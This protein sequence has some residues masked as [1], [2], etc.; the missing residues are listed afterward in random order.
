MIMAILILGV[1]GYM[2]GKFLD[3]YFDSE[4]VNNEFNNKN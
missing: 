2:W 4:E 3:D 1:L